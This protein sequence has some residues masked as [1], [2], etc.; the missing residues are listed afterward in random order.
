MLKVVTPIENPEMSLYADSKKRANIFFR[1]ALTIGIAY[2]IIIFS[3]SILYKI[4]RDFFPRYTTFLKIL[5]IGVILFLIIGFPIY[6]GLINWYESKDNGRNA[7]ERFLKRYK[8]GKIPKLLDMSIYN[9]ID[10]K[11]IKAGD[12]ISGIKTFVLLQFYENFYHV[13]IFV[14]IPK[15]VFDKV[16]PVVAHEKH[17]LEYVDSKVV[18][19]SN[20]GEHLI[21]SNEEIETYYFIH[22]LS[23]NQNKELNKLYKKIQQNSLNAKKLVKNYIE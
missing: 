11:K 17:S 9:E 7:V 19:T 4:L 23:I 18:I 15:D 10:E 8:K 20:T 2:I 14:L 3:S 21:L 16:I 13:P 12:V 1:T 5:F 22:K 6:I